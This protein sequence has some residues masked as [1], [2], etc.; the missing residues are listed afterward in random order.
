[1]RSI[2]LAGL[3]GVS[4]VACTTVSKFSIENRL[5]ELGFD[6]KRAGCWAD[7]LDKNLNSRELSEFAE[8]TGTLTRDDAGEVAKSLGKISNPRIAKA[9]S[10]AGV[11]CLIPRS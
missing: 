9:V 5:V 1:M 4:L 3:I 11:N 10:L 7:E 8:F 6:R 2:F